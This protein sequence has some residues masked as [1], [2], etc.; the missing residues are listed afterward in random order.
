VTL[1]A[2]HARAS[3][4]TVSRVADVTDLVFRR[5]LRHDADDIAALHADSWRRHYRGAYS[6]SFLDGD[7][8]N[9]RRA[10]WRRRLDDITRETATVVA[11]DDESLVGFVHVAFDDDPRWGALIDNLH[12]RY[13]QARTGVGTRLMTEAAAAVRNRPRPSG[14][15]LWVL[16]QNRAGQAFYDALGGRCVDQ[17]LVAPPGGDP[18]RLHGTPVKLRYVWD[19]P[20][21]SR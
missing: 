7:V 10:V 12:V 1:I 9:D 5:A 13:A 17:A 6:D 18:S 19:T 8:E 16:E 21:L 11:T 20:E 15:Y 2:V 4:A 14:I 3:T